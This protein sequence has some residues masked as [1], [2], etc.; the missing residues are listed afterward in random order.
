MKEFS[1]EESEYI[2]LCDLMKIADMTSSGAEAKH[3]IADGKVKVDGAIEL[4]KRCKI[5]RD[6]VVEFQGQAVKVA[7]SSSEFTCPKLPAIPLL[8]GFSSIL[9]RVS[10]VCSVEVFIS[11]RFIVGVLLPLMTGPPLANP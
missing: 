5:R 4:R 1:L 3:L 2:A 6:Q 10:S 11:L 9:S 7:S 8:R